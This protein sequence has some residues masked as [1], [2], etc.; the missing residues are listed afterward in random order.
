MENAEYSIAVFITSLFGETSTP[1]LRC[2]QA[3]Q[4]FEQGKAKDV[5]R[6]LQN[7]V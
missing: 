4:F 3:L 1:W 5:A 2:A 6:E 7:W